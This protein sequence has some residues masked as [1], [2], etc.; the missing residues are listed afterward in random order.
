M[1][2]RFIRGC[3][4]P[5][6]EPH[7][8]IRQ[9]VEAAGGTARVAREMRAPTFQGTLHKICSGHVKSPTRRS[10]ERISRF[11]GIPVDAVYKASVA[12]QVAASR[13][14]S[15]PLAVREAAPTYSVVRALPPPNRPPDP[16]Y[17]RE[18]DAVATLLRQVAPELRQPLGVLLETWARA[19]G[20]PEMRASLE[21]LLR[22]PPDCLP[23][24]EETT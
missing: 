4:V 1:P 3:I 11:F 8:L 23:T 2:H 20:A 16:L 12:Q 10:A 21:C 18:L 14:L 13:Q 22:V 19:G 5:R 15:T 17:R 7:D 9:L 6:M 24:K